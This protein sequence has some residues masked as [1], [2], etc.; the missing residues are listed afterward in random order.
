MVSAENALVYPGR[1]KLDARALYMFKP[2]ISSRGKAL[3]ED[4]QQT[5]RLEL[6]QRKGYS[7]A[8][9]HI[10]EGNLDPMPSS[11]T[12]QRKAWTIGIACNEFNFIRWA[13][14]GLSKK[15]AHWGI[16]IRP[17]D[18]KVCHIFK[19]VFM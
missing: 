9:Y 12:Y 17:H 8:F 4:N 7:I 16:Y 10:S 19:F 2:E 18:N 3:K 1:Q 11:N 13:P 14:S 15:V 5:S 6:F